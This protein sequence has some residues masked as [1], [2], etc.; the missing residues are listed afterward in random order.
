MFKIYF[1]LIMPVF[2]N[3]YHFANKEIIN[4]FLKNN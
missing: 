1:L 3:K 4:F 2:I